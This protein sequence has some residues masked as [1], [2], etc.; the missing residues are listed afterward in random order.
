VLGIVPVAPGQAE[1]QPLGNAEREY[2]A[3]PGWYMGFVDGALR[4]MPGWEIS[5]AGHPLTLAVLVPGTRQTV[6]N[7]ENPPF[8][9]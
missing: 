9:P 8:E 7:A 2:R 4:I 6:R 3:V 1:A 5:V